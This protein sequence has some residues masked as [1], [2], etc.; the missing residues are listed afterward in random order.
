LEEN[1]LDLQEVQGYF[2]GCDHEQ[3]MNGVELQC[4]GCSMEIV[5]ILQSEARMNLS[6]DTEP[7][8]D[9][10]HTSLVWA[11]ETINED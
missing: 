9:Q 7:D 5:C 4:I 8:C 6:I 3:V 1:V 2:S 11:E 10:V